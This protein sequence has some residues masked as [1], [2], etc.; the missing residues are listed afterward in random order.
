MKAANRKSRR[1]RQE[2]NISEMP[3]GR[4]FGQMSMGFDG[5]GKRIRKRVYGDSKA[6]VIEKMR[7]KRNEAG[8]GMLPE[9]DSMTVGELLDRWLQIKKPSFSVR[10]FEER[11]ATIDNHL[12]PRIGGLRL[13]KM[14]PLHVEGLYANMAEAKIGLPTIRTAANLLGTVLKY[15]A[16]KKLI[17]VNPAADVEKPKV[18]ERDMIALDDIQAKH[19]LAAATKSQV[20]AIVTTAL[21]TG[22]RQGELLAL[23]WSAVDLHN[24]TINVRVSLAQSRDGTFHVK[25]PKTKAGKRII[26]LPANVVSVLVEHKATMM[27]AGRLEHPVFSTRTGNWLNK[28][29]VLRAFRCVV[30]RANA[31]ITKLMKEEKPI[32]AGRAIAEMIRF[33][34]LRH[35]CAS[36][37]LSKG[38]SLKAVSA[39]L[40]HANPAFTLRVYAHCL[41]NDD[42]T[43]ANEL[44]RMFA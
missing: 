32:E 34:D 28:N 22:M 25:E 44:T 31:N 12:R 30:K 23:D 17:A 3:N 26:N 2:G 33:H 39:R 13:A 11:K 20:N 18:T 4:W 5:N 42:A 16:K 19:V 10:T 40:G 7:K 43:L 24:K 37:L 38:C 35:S 15:A 27:K 21:G 41:P 29:N 36:L 14:N 1:G 9:A 6:E 8:L